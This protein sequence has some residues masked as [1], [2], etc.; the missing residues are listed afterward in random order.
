MEP[1]R[2]NKYL[3]DQG[4]ASRR[5]ADA[6]VAAG[7]VLVNGK[8][9]E[10]GML[11]SEKDKV[12]VSNRYKKEYVYYA[13]FKPRGLSTQANKGQES[14]IAQLKKQGL[15]PIGRLDK[16]S[17]GLLIV[18]NDGRLTD[19]VLGSGIEK[20]YVIKLREHLRKG[21]PAIFQKGMETKAFG[22]L[23]PA[24]AEVEDVHTLRVTLKEG[25]RHQLRVMLDELHFTIESLKRVRIGPVSLEGMK[26]GETRALRDREVEQLFKV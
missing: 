1:I 3:R 17:E 14:V 22:K 2:I 7:L 9:A 19:H 12:Q 13:Y 25:K 11:V 8:P 21:I 6:L 10:Q 15:F 18:T 26:A 24:K 4:I 23:L 20:E 5:E 16:E